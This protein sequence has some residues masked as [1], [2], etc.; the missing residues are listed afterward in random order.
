MHEFI[1]TLAEKDFEALEA[2]GILK[3]LA[4]T[5]LGKLFLDFGFHAPTVAWPEAFGVMIEPTESYTK[6]ELDRFEEAVRHILKIVREK[7]EALN[8]TP[9]FTPIDR[10]DEVSANRH[11]ILSESL[12]QLPK[13]S[14][15]RL[16]PESL[17]EMSVPEIF[18]KIINSH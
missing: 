8:Q 10:V 16:D 4:V 6:A 3:A 13:L 11:L 17:A 2:V 12:Q 1:L 7:P 15:N 9:F 14:P 18:N 5:R